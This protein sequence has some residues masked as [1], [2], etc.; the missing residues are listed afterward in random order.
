M[1]LYE[2]LPL[3]PEGQGRQVC[4]DYTVDDVLMAYDMHHIAEHCVSCRFP[5]ILHGNGRL[6]DH[7][8]LQRRATY[9]HIFDVMSSF[10]Q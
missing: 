10:Q 8:D 2:S 9:R 4:A 3:N 1:H 5:V 6:K 7:S